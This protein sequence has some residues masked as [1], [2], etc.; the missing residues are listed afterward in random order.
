[1]VQVAFVVAV[2]VETPCA[3]AVG[4]RAEGPMVDGVVEPA[5]ADMAGQDC[6]FLA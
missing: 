1:M 6:T 4:E 3:G 5:V 2:V